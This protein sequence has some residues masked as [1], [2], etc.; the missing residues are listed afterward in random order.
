MTYKERWCA[1]SYLRQYY[2]QPHVSDDVEAAMRFVADEAKQRR[3][4]NVRIL[5]FGSGPAI[6]GP[7]PLSPVA[8]AIHFA[9]FMPENLTNIRQW[10][11]NEPGTHDWS[12]YVDFAH[13]LCSSTYGN[14]SVN[15][16]DFQSRFRQLICK[17]YYADIYS[18]QPV[19]SEFNTFDVVI[20]NYCLECIQRQKSNW[21][22]FLKRLADLV[23]P[24]G[25]LF[26]TSILHSSEYLVEGNRFP[27]TTL[28][29]Q[30]I[31]SELLSLHFPDEHICLKTVP[32]SAWKNEGIERICLA[33][34]TKR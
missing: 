29:V 25:T 33:A 10:A 16:A 9:D 3:L 24:G 2:S 32:I 13:Q 14:D 8:S 5:D 34:A 11:Q 15:P 1:M 18:D 28:S 30:D 6:W 21:K 7:L 17:S 26:L 23:K 31:Q 20:S 4:S 22:I 27:V 12:A 19:L